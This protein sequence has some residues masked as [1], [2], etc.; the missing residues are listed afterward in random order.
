MTH[1]NVTPRPTK[2][3]I[4]QLQ[5][6]IGLTLDRIHLPNKPAQFEFARRE[7]LRERFIGFDTET[8]PTFTKGEVATGPHVAQFA[9]R[10]R[11]FV[12]R[13]E[14]PGAREF[15]KDI[16]ESAEIVKV[17]FGLS[18]DRGPL[19]RKIGARIRST[20]DLAAALRKKGFRQ[21]VGAKAAVAIVLGRRLQ[22]S[23]SVTTSN[24]ARQS[25]LPNQLLYA[26]N[27]AYAAL[28]VFYALGMHLAPD[29]AT[30]PCPPVDPTANDQPVS[31]AHPSR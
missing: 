12:V 24:W 7:L 18:S 11:A 21:T 23:K 26:A 27:D 2:Q 31:A 8:K 14:D 4:A 13:V 10:E 28:A 17:G 20:V 22:K 6:F 15:I 19:L 3:E 25:L 5:P 30:A 16:V 1:A 9:V 29:P